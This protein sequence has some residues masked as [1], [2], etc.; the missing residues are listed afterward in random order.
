MGNLQI[1]MYMISSFYPKHTTNFILYSHALYVNC[2]CSDPL[3]C[4]IKTVK[5]DCKT[6]MGN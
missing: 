6:K 3:D 4:K 2:I 1:A 5:F